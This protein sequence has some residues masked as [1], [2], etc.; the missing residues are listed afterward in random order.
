[1]CLPRYCLICR[2]NLQTSESYL[3]IY[4]LCNLP[5]TN[6][7]TQAD[8]PIAAKF[9]GILPIQTAM[10]LYR[11]TQSGCIQKLIHEIKY[12]NTPELAMLLGRHYGCLLKQAGYDQHID[13]ILPV[14]LHAS[15]LLTRGYNQSD[16]LAKGLAATLGVPWHSRYINRIRPTSTQTAQNR[17]TRWQ[18][19]RKSFHVPDSTPLI[20]KAILLV[21][22]VITTGATMVSCAQALYTSQP[23]SITLAALAARL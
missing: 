12:N 9:Y 18:N 16:L 19:P 7:H 13:L 21:D 20:G 17:Q 15:K 23:K 22:D 5:E 11:F 6:T 4:C 10:V 8:N 1:M 14:P 3:C 2:T